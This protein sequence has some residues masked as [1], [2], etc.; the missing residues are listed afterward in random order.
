MTLR[1]ILDRQDE[2]QAVGAVVAGRSVAGVREVAVAGTQDVPVDA[3][4]R[5]GSRASTR[6]TCVNV[7]RHCERMGSAAGRKRCAP[8]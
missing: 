4:F 3:R 7:S 2:L 5:I 1:D 8:K 6:T